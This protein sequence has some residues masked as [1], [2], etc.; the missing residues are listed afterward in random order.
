LPNQRRLHGQITDGPGCT[1]PAAFEAEWQEANRRATLTGPRS[2]SIDA[3]D[4][5]HHSEPTTQPVTTQTTE[6]L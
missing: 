1:T 3:D 4:T 6:P 5:N 2:A